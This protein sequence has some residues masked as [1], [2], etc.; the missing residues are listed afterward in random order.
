[1][2]L[3]WLC[4]YSQR[5]RTSP[6]HHPNPNPLLPCISA[7]A[8]CTLFSGGGRRRRRRW[9]ICRAACFLRLKRLLMSP[10]SGLGPPAVL[11]LLASAR[12]VASFNH[13]VTPFPSP[14]PNAAHLPSRYSSSQLLSAGD[15]HAIPNSSRL[16]RLTYDP[17]LSMSVYQP[18]ATR[19]HG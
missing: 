10:C 5:G 17:F 1:M 3:P 16:P 11:V 14:L 18:S 19:P 2:T 9:E 7:A 8:V 4:M 15:T 12:A 6:L 13:S